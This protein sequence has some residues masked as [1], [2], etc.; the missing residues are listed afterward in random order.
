MPSMTSV[1][2]PFADC[3]VGWVCF[4]CLLSFQ[5]LDAN[6][7]GTSASHGI[8]HARR[9]LRTSIVRCR[10]QCAFFICTRCRTAGVSAVVSHANFNPVCRQTPG[11]INR[12]SQQAQHKECD[13]PAR[14]LRYFVICHGLAHFLK[15]V[16]HLAKFIV[17]L[18]NQL[19]GRHG[20]HP[21]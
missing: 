18:V 16:A 7:R 12:Q 20:T 5:P 4:K 3:N 21:V 8:G 13:Q 14:F 11:R 17:S 2:E 19:F 9:Y 15:K 6:R 1:P 10:P